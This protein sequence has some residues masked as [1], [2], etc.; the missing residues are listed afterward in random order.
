MI[1]SGWRIYNWHP[2]LAVRFQLPR[3]A[4]RWAAIR[5]SHR[6]LH[7]EPGV[8]NAH[9]LAF[10]RDVAAGS[11]AISRLSWLR[12]PHRPFPAR[13]P[14][15]RAARFLRDFIAARDFRLQHRLGE[16][17][18]VQRVFYWGVMAAIVVMIA[19]RPRHLEAGATQLARPGC[20]AAF[21]G[22]RVVHFLFMAAIVG[23]IVD[24]C[25]AGGRWCRRPS[26]R[27]R[28]GRGTAVPHD[29]QPGDG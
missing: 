20:S 4:P 3:R 10:R 19:L 23:F 9:R 24:P 26:S 2:D 27:W 21:Q 5:R 6:S 17:N 14:A 7:D 22:A 8:A 29:A 16:Y 28:S 13:F 25:R 12:H 18:A 11:S 15:G 1:G